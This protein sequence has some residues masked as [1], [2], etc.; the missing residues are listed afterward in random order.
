MG[1]CEQTCP[2]TVTTPFLSTPLAM[3]KKTKYLGF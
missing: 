3:R 2:K 1:T